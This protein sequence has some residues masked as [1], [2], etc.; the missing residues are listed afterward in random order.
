MPN[1]NHHRRHGNT[2]DWAI[3]RAIP[4]ASHNLNHHQINDRRDAHQLYAS[5][6]RDQMISK[7]NR[8]AKR[9]LQTIFSV[10]HCIILRL[11]CTLSVISRFWY[12]I[13]TSATDL[14]NKESH[15]ESRLE[16]PRYHGRWKHIGNFV[17]ENGVPWIHLTPT[18]KNPHCLGDSK[19][20]YVVSRG[21]G[22][23]Q[24]ARRRG[25]A[26]RGTGGT[27]ARPSSV[28]WPHGVLRD[29]K[30]P[31]RRAAQRAAERTWQDPQ[32]SSDR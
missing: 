30:A 14:I 15:V 11:I 8:F 32:S 2:F 18:H 25:V 27:A 4:G 16:E 19:F 13:I 22:G 12:D 23:P 3:N 6:I 10:G 31:S 20:C 5:N 26:A 24:I 21:T 29:G 17:D 1:I 28:G 7:T 9:K